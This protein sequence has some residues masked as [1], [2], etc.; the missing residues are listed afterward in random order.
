MQFVHL[1]SPREEPAKTKSPARTL[2]VPFPEPKQY[3]NLM[4]YVSN[5]AKF[6]IFFVFRGNYQFLACALELY[7]QTPWPLLACGVNPSS[8]CLNR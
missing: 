6:I 5:C 3:P 7:P 2:R 4:Y 1:L 8:T